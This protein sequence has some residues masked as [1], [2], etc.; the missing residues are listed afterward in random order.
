MNA[1]EQVAADTVISRMEFLEEVLL[2]AEGH[3]NVKEHKVT[4]TKILNTVHDKLGNLLK[5][6]WEANRNGT[7]TPRANCLSG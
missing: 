4:D 1:K 3:W 5:E 2:A 6:N 7:I